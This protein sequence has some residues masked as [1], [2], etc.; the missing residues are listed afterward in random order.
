MLFVQLGHLVIMPEYS[1]ELSKL[2][3]NKKICLVTLMMSF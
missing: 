3:F 1:E 2:L